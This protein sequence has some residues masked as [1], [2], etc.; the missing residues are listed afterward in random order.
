MPGVRASEWGT[1]GFRV[2]RELTDR[3]LRVPPQLL[4]VGEG[5]SGC[6][7]P[8]TSTNTLAQPGGRVADTGGGCYT[9]LSKHANLT[10]DPLPLYG[11][12]PTLVVGEQTFEHTARP[13]EM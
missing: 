3:M 7:S 4:V 5:L 11:P 10:I 12:T 6:P 9:I 13:K 1:P 8:L 2:G